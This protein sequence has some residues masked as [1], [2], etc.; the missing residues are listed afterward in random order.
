[1]LESKIV[2]RKQLLKRIFTRH[3][4]FEIGKALAIPYFS[5]FLS[6]WNIDLDK[7]TLEISL[8][9]NDLQ[10]KEFTEQF[11]PRKW[12]TFSGEHYTYRNGELQSEGS[13]KSI[14]LAVIQVK[15]KYGKNLD[16]VL[17]RILES[18]QG[19][20]EKEIK[21]LLPSQV[22]L[23]PILSDL[24][25]ADVTTASYK[26]K[27][28]KEWIVREEVSPIIRRE[29]GLVKGIKERIKAQSVQPSE[30]PSPYDEE[31]KT[32]QQMDQEF[33][34]YLQQLLKQ[35]VEQ[36]LS[37]GRSF[38]IDS[39]I[40][41]LKNM[42]GSTLYFDAMLAITQ[43]Y[44]LADVEIHHQKGDT[45]MRTGWNLALFGD[46]G[47]GK[48]F[49]TRDLILG[50]SEK[51]RPH[52][53]PGRNRYAGGITPARF[54][55]IGHAYSGRT[56]NFIIPE[57]N[58]WFKYKGMV[59]SLKI[60][61]EHGEVKYETV[62]EVIGPYRLTS[63]FS[64]NYNVAVSGRGYEVTVAD[65]NFN[66]IEDRMLCRLHRLTKQRFEEIAESQMRLALGKIDLEK[67]AQQIRDHLTLVYAIETAHPQVKEKFLKKPVML[68]D[69]T[70][71]MLT[72]T[73]KAILSEIPRE[74]VGF[75]ARLEN[76][77]LSLACAASLLN[78]FQSE[79]DY[80]TVSEAALKTAI[81]LYVEEAAVRS[82]GE[83]SSETV[84]EKLSK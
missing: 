36:T 44:G 25:K 81:Q 65:P 31:S 1:M 84:L 14:Q 70:L 23:Q 21:N 37:F 38:S 69:K 50:K 42:F 59:E 16:I 22:N 58:E 62:R 82:R 4:I 5:D 18:P 45:G 13:W 63:F 68:T 39:L 83:F 8:N 11:K 33:E 26:G 24:E 40:Q 47:T 71:K 28:L 66:A 72:E 60:A 76:R 34:N 49:S 77:A 67:G 53:I 55:R 52:G 3:Q 15:R 80:I 64:V 32:I 35:R 57:F 73:R 48:S 51:V 29:L 78:Y 79:D 7:A 12:Q 2:E 43:Q 56:F 54:I 27:E 41:Y 74:N 17:K 6:K 19:V 10:L 30:K 61:M 46:P 20:S 75:S 9:I